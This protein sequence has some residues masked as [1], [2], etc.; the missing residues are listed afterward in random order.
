MFNCVS[1]KYI[2]N[3]VSTRLVT[4]ELTPYIVHFTH[5]NCSATYPPTQVLP[6]DESTVYVRHPLVLLTCC[7]G[8]GAVI[9]VRRHLAQSF[10]TCTT[11]RGLLQRQ[12]RDDRHVIQCGRSG[13]T[14]QHFS[15][16][17]DTFM[18]YMYVK[19]FLYKVFAHK[20]YFTRQTGS[21]SQII[22]LLS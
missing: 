18:A 3:S 14:C 19:F 20:Q 9:V 12:R 7:H 16:T 4:H 1:K 17:G 2:Y 5:I 13:F 10:Q 21:Y 8:N 15:V 6:R 22:V 11:V